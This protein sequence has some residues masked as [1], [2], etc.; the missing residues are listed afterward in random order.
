[1]SLRSQAIDFEEVLPR[2]ASILPLP[3]ESD[4]LQ[5]TVEKLKAYAEIVRGGKSLAVHTGFKATPHSERDPTKLALKHM[6][7]PEYEAYTAWSD[8]ID[9][10]RF[11]WKKN[12]DSVPT[13]KDSPRRFAQRAAAMNTAWKTDKATAEHAAWLTNNRS[14]ILPLLKALV[15]IETARVDLRGGLPE[16]DASALAEYQTINKIRSL[17]VQAEQK[18]MEAIRQL[19]AEILRHMNTLKERADSL[20]LKK[21]SGQEKSEVKV[22]KEE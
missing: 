4:E 14:E 9:L 15:R 8:G 13:G 2:G 3:N 5:E 18:Q 22:E 6:T 19:E 17:A 7:I 20:E 12:K 1:M 11:D 10:G 21:P 16:Q